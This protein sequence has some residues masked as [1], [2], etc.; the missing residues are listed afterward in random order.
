VLAP[1][2]LVSYSNLKNYLSA[3][4]EDQLE[5]H[6]QTIK[7]LVDKNL[8][9]VTS[10]RC[11]ATLFGFSVKF[12]HALGESNTKYYRDFTIRK[13]LKKRR[14]QAPKVALKVIQRWFSQNLSIAVSFP[15]Y[16]YGFV[17][18]RSAPQ[19]A[20][21]HCGAAWVYSVDIENFFPSTPIEAIKPGLKALGYS[22]EACDVILPICCFGQNLAQ[23]AP[24]SP[25]LS[26]IAL[27]GVDEQL[28]SLS[29]R[30]ELTYTRYADDIVFS[31]FGHFPED[32][33]A[34]VAEVFS[35]TCWALNSDK[36]YF[37]D[38]TKGQRLKIHGLLVNDERPK[39]TKGYRNK[40][41]AY[42][43]MLAA[44]KVSEEDLARIKGHI[45]YAKSIESIGSQ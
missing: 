42:K 32:L 21:R 28:Y 43:H 4:S 45:N 14:I 30:L 1:P 37:A 5:E 41:R 7:I 11:L 18:G 44:G 3:L 40:L 13:G 26:N 29:K 34:K 17:P 10:R 22:G 16:V 25:I 33:P 9:P 2:L 23:G 12:V 39:L 15:E 35:E 24:S 38:S 19:A 20:M 8:P 6:G 36:E 27:A 31:G